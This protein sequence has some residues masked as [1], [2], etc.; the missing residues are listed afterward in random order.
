MY[1]RTKTSIP[2]AANRKTLSQPASPGRTNGHSLPVNAKPD[3][4]VL[5]QKHFK[6]VGPRTYAAQVK[7]LA[8]GNHLLVLIE[9]KRDPKT[10]EVRKTRL[11]VFGEDFPA[12]FRMLHETAAFLR[13]N[14]LSEEVRRRREKFWSRKSKEADGALPPTNGRAV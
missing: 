7:E 9:G 5:F 12:F 3:P 13:A 11:F 1:M 8:N 6:S 2:A 4:I 14:P 10:D